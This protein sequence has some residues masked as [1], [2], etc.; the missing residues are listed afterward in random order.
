MLSF[1]LFCPDFFAFLDVFLTV[2]I[3][4]LFKF[5]DIIYII[6]FYTQQFL[7]CFNIYIHI[8]D[9]FGPPPCMIA[10]FLQ[11]L[12]V[13]TPGLKITVEQAGPSGLAFDCRH[14]HLVYA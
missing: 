12:Q 3:F 7:P 8:S 5:S 4:F 11:H 2:I 13:F 9:V 6:F 10:I 14:V 1:F